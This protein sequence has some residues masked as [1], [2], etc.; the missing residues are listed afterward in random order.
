MFDPKKLLDQFLGPQGQGQGGGM[1]QKAEDAFGLAQRNPLK[2]SA[3]A[4]ALLGT[5]TGRKLGG[6]ALKY[7][8]IAAIAGLGYYAFKS[9][10]AGQTPQ[11]PSGV[12]HP[13]PE[14]LP[15]PADSPF[16]PQAPEA[17][18]DFAL[19]LLRVMIAAAKADGHIDADER[20]RIMERLKGEELDGE[21]E[22]FIA[23]ELAQTTDL[24]GIVAACRTEA[25]KI[26][27]FTA[28][29]VAIEPDSRAER[30]FLDMLAGRLGLADPLVDHIDAAVSAAK[31]SA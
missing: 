23:K 1:R 11:R 31:V 25:Q 28:A 26:E 5:K 22:A 9:Y 19:A 8:G 17:G 30:G 27:L 24:D 2:T 15:P 29:R 14:L 12:H 20:A 10:Q 3:L 6:N 13:E 21:A 4:A 16:S 7:G 18:D